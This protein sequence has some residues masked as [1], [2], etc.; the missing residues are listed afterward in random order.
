MR[1]SHQP[2][3]GPTRTGMMP[4][5]QFQPYG[6][7]RARPNEHMNAEAGLSTLMPPLI[8]YPALPTAGPSGGL[9]ETTADAEFDQ[10]IT[11]EDTAPVSNF[12]CS[13]IRHV[14]ERSFGVRRPD[15]PGGRENRV[16]GASGLIR[17]P[18]SCVSGRKGGRA[19]RGS[20]ATKGLSVVSTCLVL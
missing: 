18:T 14:T 9:S 1:T 11:E 16:T 13:H 15:N 6:T 19:F 3:T 7:P 2:S 12:Y 8:P 20:Q 5:W 4:G 17:M 10:P